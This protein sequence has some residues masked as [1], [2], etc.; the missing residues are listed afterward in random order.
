MPKEHEE[1]DEV[2]RTLRE[3]GCAPRVPGDDV[4]KEEEEEE[5]IEYQSPSS[6]ISKKGQ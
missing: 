1:D 4:Q 5:E 2:T 3:E 6:K